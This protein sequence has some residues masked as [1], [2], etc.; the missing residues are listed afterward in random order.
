V[1]AAA[2]QAIEGDGA[3]PAFETLKTIGL[4]V[5][6]QVCPSASGAM[7]RG[8]PLKQFG[9]GIT[10]RQA[11]KLGF[12]LFALAWRQARLPLQPGAPFPAAH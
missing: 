4:P 1:A 5:A 7:R 11:L 8:D 9:Y 6:N 2:R 10:A 12:D 3:T